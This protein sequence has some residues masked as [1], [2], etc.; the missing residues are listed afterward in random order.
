MKRK[1]ITYED[2]ADMYDR[3]GLE[4][5]RMPPAELESTYEQITNRNFCTKD[6][7]ISANSSEPSDCFYTL[8]SL[9]K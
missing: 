6:Y 8:F 9:N 1:T 4:S 5:M 7:T 2:V 3:L